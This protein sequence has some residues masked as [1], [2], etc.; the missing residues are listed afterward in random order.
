MESMTGVILDSVR[1]RRRS[2]AGEPEAR[3]MAVCDPRPLADAPVITT[4]AV[5]RS[6]Y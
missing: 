1:P 6:L 4:G 5:S 2:V 3:K